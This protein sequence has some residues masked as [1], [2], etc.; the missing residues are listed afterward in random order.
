MVD[1]E[2]IYY[3]FLV[4]QY[5]P[6]QLIAAAKSKID[7]AVTRSKTPPVIFGRQP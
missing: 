1:K 2:T 7:A 6:S 3:G 5:S 4:N